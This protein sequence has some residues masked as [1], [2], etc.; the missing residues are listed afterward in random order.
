MRNGNEEVPKERLKHAASSYRTYEEW[1]RTK[2]FAVAPSV[3]G[4]YRT[5]EEWKHSYIE[6]FFGSGQGSYRTYE[7]WKLGAH[8]TS[9]PQVR[10]FLP[11]L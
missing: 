1:K 5:Y 10:S 7:E 9:Y 8:V 6:P 2:G 4:S 11:Y 3:V